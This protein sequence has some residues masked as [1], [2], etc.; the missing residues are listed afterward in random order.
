MYLQEHSASESNAELSLWRIGPRQAGF[1]PLS[2]IGHPR[3][4]SA[5]HQWPPY[6]GKSPLNNVRRSAETVLVYPQAMRIVA[7]TSGSRHKSPCLIN[8]TS[9]AA[10]QLT[11]E[12]VE[13]DSFA[14]NHEPTA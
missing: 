13:L 1:R 7:F 8:P 9:G 4:C 6:A 5:P 3:S 11:R 2:F 14:A 12:G 10:L